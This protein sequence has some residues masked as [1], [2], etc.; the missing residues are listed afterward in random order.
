MFHVD[1]NELKA[2][3]SLAN[4]EA[5]A[6]QMRLSLL[7]NYSKAF[8]AAVKFISAEE[9]NE[10]GTISFHHFNTKK[11]CCATVINQIVDKQLES[12]PSGNSV[13]IAINRRK[14]FEFMDTGNVD[15]EG[16]YS[17]FGQIVQ[18]LI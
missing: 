17:I 8:N 1:K 3:S 5:A 18:Q 4:I 14:A 7:V 2:E 13:E 6:L 11:M 9:R 12:I 10:P 15:V 16:K